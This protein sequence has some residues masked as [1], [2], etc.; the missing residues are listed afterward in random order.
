MRKFELFENRSEIL[1]FLTVI[2]SIFILN[3]G[4]EWVKF[5]E[6][7]SSKFH[8][9]DAKVEHS[10]LKTKNSKTYR[11]LKLDS[12]EFSF[13]TTTKKDANIS[14]YDRLN[15]GVVTSSI[16]Y[17]DWLKKRFYLPSFKIKKL[18]PKPNFKQNI[19]NFIDS[20]HSSDKIKELYV[21]L[22]LATP[23]SKELRDDVTKW[24]IAHV[25]SISGF[26]LGIIFGVIFLTIT[27]IYR[28]FQ[29]RFFPYR[30]SYFDI[31]IF[32][33]CLMVFYLFLLD[34]TPSF[35]RSLVMAFIGFLFLIKNIRILSFYTLFLTILLSV[36][37]IPHL[38]FSIGFYFSCLGV[39]YI[40]LYAHHFGEIKYTK[41]NI[42]THAILLNLYVYFAMNIPVYHFFHTL[43]FSQIAVI[44]IGYIFVIFYPVSILLHIFGVGNLMDGMLL[45][46][47]NYEISTFQT[48]IPAPL[49]YIMN[50]LLLPAIRYKFIA[51]FLAFIGILPLF[52]IV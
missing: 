31:S 2:I 33:F 46:F 24:G 7:K 40:Y 32:A 17:K 44:P 25:V 50:L 5:K 10:Y 16:S 29:R 21:T 36:S 13:Y 28:Y 47:L 42:I 9:L 4:Y 35:L 30:S 12:G 18:K 38:L 41:F 11:V 22:Y 52:F 34:F 3:L 48:Q 1:I 51:L 27:P 20:Q 43:A 45:E 49:F 37:F 14:R 15:L 8:F 6:F 26:H 19:I 23:I 39:F